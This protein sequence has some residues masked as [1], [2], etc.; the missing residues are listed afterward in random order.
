MIPLTYVLLLG[1]V[2]LLLLSPVGAFGLLVLVPILVVM[3]FKW[4]RDRAAGPH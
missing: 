3:G 4:G 1:A 2:L